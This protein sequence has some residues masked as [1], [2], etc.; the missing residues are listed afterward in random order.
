MQNQT[1]YLA[2]FNLQKY[3]Q[4]NLQILNNV[5]IFEANGLPHRAHVT[6]T[7]L[8]LLLILIGI[9]IKKICHYLLSYRNKGRITRE[10]L[11]V[12]LFVQYVST[13]LVNSCYRN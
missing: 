2:L 8:A 4:N 7:A 9:I 6:V 5:N 11:Q 12:G 10:Y 1:Q 13:G 3:I